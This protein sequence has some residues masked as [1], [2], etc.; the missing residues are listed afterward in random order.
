MDRNACRNDEQTLACEEQERKNT[1]S[2]ETASE[3]DP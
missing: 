2:S 3:A 1:L